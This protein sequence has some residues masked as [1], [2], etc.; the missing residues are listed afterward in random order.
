M[1][2]LTTTDL[3]NPIHKGKVRDTYDLGGG[4]LLMVATDRI[5]AFDVVLPT[6]IPEKGIVLTEISAF[7]FNKTKHIIDNHMVALSEDL[8]PTSSQFQNIP[9]EVSK[10]GMVVNRANRLDVECIV[11]GYLAGS[12][13][14]EYKSKGTIFGSKAPE[15]MKEGQKLETPIFT[16]TTKAEIGHDENITIEEMKGIFGEDLTNQLEKISI[17]LYNYANDYSVSK[18]KI[19]ADT[20]FEF[21]IIN[22]KLTIIDEVL[23]PD[24]SRFW[25]LSTFEEGSQPPN[26]DKQFVRDWLDTSGWNHEPPAPELPEEIVNKTIERYKLAFEMLTKA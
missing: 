13:W 1:S 10:R 5:S 17:E 15:G 3:P 24:S 21:G 26:F 11:R 4:F 7:W 18:G 12:A 14:G 23:T 22:D 19:L 2:L 6:G 16:P 9:E 25:D 8:A 20:K